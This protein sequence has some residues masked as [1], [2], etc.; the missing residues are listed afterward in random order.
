MTFSYL[1]KLFCVAFY[2]KI[3]LRCVPFLFGGMTA[4][5]VAAEN[6]QYECCKLLVNNGANLSAAFNIRADL[7]SQKRVLFSYRDSRQFGNVAKGTIVFAR[8]W[9][10]CA[11]SDRRP[12]VKFTCV[13]IQ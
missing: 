2:Q 1:S 12:Y 9:I 3:V 5:A 7:S 8:P 13:P 6:Q 4:L 11:S 10:S